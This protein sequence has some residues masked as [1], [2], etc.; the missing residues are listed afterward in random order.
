MTQAILLLAMSVLTTVGA[1]LC[2]KQ[3]VLNLGTLNFS[4]SGFF[5]LILRVLQNF[6]LVGGLFLFGISYLLWLLLLSKFQL[7]V[8]YPITVGFNFCLI[9]I[10][11]WFLF[12]EYLS[13][14]QILGIAIIMLG[15]FLVLPKGSI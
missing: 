1:Q 6:W 9:T 4:L 14:I 13:P 3:G 15:V 8:I 11:S 2:L 5:L 10:A 12:K 7:S